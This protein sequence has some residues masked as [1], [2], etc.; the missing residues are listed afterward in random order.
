[1]DYIKIKKIY[2][3]HTKVLSKL[4]EKESFK[5]LL[6]NSAALQDVLIDQLKVIKFLESRLSD[7]ELIKQVIEQDL[8]SEIIDVDQLNGFS[9]LKEK[10]H[11]ITNIIIEA[12][13]NEIKK[14]SEAEDL[15]NY[16]ELF[17]KNSYKK[18]INDFLFEKNTI[19]IKQQNDFINKPKVDLQ[20]GLNSQGIGFNNNNNN[21]N[22]MG[23]MMQSSYIQM[24]EAKL[25]A[26]IRQGKYFLY[27]SKP[28]WFVLFKRI[29]GGFLFFVAF[30]IAMMLLF[31]QLSGEIINIL[32]RNRS[33]VFFGGLTSFPVITNFISIFSACVLGFFLLKNYRNDNERF[34]IPRGFFYFLIFVF[35]FNITSLF[36]EVIYVYVDGIS[37]Y[38]ESG[39]EN[40]SQKVIERAADPKPVGFASHV[41]SFFIASASFSILTLVFT[42]IVIF[43][44]SFI[45]FTAPKI[46]FKRRQLKIESLID[47]IK[48]QKARS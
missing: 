5:K 25:N 28:H 48:S 1:M 38:R 21:N 23:L 26:E 29:L 43:L 6:L 15:I 17:L 34:S 44:L 36:N 33:T 46:D 22:F 18:N 31:R 41:V 24:A 9:F 10:V 2:L 45:I 13:A 40:F 7:L 39:I 16:F 20:N 14:L 27:D 47:E 3:S 42:A 11:K 8:K 4:L 12:N 37:I 35:I 19:N 32:S 30:L